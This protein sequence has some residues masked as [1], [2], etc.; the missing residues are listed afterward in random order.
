[1]N[2]EDIWVASI[3]TPVRAAVDQ[4]FVDDFSTLPAATAL[5]EWNI[6]SPLWA[7][8]AIE[9]QNG[10]NVLALHDK[11]PF[12]FAKAERVVP[13]SKKLAASFS[14]VPQQ[15]SYGSLQ[16][17]F[18]DAKG[19]AGIRMILDSTGSLVTKAGYRYKK[20]CKYAAGEKMDI[21]VELNT[22]ARF[23]TVTV[24]GKV[25]GGANLFFAPLDHVQ[26]VTF[27]T[28]DLRRFPDADTPT[29]QM[30]DLPDAGRMDKEAIYYLRN[31]SIQ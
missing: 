24:N 18:V 29:D 19:N 31:F 21:K 27:R 20:L 25:E 8:V 1:M 26:R 6:Y 22:A 23:Y 5:N 30:Y 17:E 10:V 3:P 11:D 12:D 7:P 15:N 14:I 9:K 28:G 16:I 4:P 2:K 13:A